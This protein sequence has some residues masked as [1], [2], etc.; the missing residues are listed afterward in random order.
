M[1]RA[2]ARAP[3]G[4]MRIYFAGAIL[5]GRENLPVYRH[6]VTHLQSL[7]HSVPSEHV[8]SPRVLEEEGLLSAR[9]VY[10]RDVAWIQECDAMI[11]EVSAPSLGVGYE[12]SFALERGKAVLCL[13]REGLIISKMITGNSCPRLNVVSYRDTAEA[14]SHIE[15]FLAT[16][17]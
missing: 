17:L 10:E 5:G 15:R 2:E 16:I 12:V 9:A 4:H 6:I 3:Y 7:G 8:A 14:D 11:A 13:M 1:A